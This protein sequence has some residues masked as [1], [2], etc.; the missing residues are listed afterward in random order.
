[1][2]PRAT[3]ATTT[4]PC[5]ANKLKGQLMDLD[6]LSW[7][8]P[9]GYEFELNKE[10][11]KWIVSNAKPSM[12]TQENCFIY[13][14]AFHEAFNAEPESDNVFE[15]IRKWAK[16]RGI[17]K[18]GDANTQFVKLLEEVGELA[19]A[20]LKDDYVAKKDAIGDI[21]VVLTN[22]SRMIGYNVEDCI[23]FAYEQIKNRQGE[24]INGTFVKNGTYP[25]GTTDHWKK[26]TL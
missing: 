15:N 17:Y 10:T 2:L 12:Y 24:M 5:P 6:G 23:D 19:E 20:L 26:V 11:I 21:I 16:E 18:M 22:L 3:E 8:T 7:L 25:E 9:Q 13:N 14:K 4:F 1:M